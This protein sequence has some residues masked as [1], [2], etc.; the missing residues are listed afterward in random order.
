MEDYKNKKKEIRLVKTSAQAKKAVSILLQE[1]E[2]RNLEKGITTLLD[3]LKNPRL[4]V[5][6]DSYPDLLQ[7]YELEQLLSGNL[8]IKNSTKQD[9]KTAGLLSCLQL[10]IHLCYELKENSSRTNTHFDSLRY[11]LSAIS[12]TRFI[13][14]LF[15]ISIAVVGE[16]HYKKFQQQIQDIDIDLEK[17][18]ALDNNPEGQEHMEIMVWLGLVRLFIEA[19]YTLYNNPNKNFKNTTV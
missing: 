5:V 14:E 4:N 15:L 6:L 12:C 19:V 2:K 7:E 10:L 3:K 17:V 1:P 16:D 11:I 13:N 9:I 8:E 18:R